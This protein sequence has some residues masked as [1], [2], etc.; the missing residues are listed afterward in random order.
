MQVNPLGCS[1]N[2]SLQLQEKEPGLLEQT[3]LQPPLSLAHS[4]MSMHVLPSEEESW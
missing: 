1:E 4:L 2:P 3:W